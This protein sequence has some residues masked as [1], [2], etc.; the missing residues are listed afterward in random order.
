MSKESNIKEIPGVFYDDPIITN[1]DWESI[2]FFDENECS[3]LWEKYISEKNRHFMKLDSDE[4]PSLLVKKESILYRWLDD[5]N[6]D[7]IEEFKNVILNLGVPIDSEV[8]FFWMKEIGVK[9]KWQIFARN[10]INFLYEDEGC[11]LVVPE[12]KCSLVLSNGRA[13]FGAINEN[14]I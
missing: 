7:N 6:N 2:Y 11:I 13:W 1:D 8:Y 3:D 9:T 4:W 14:K 12:S 10:W 5:W